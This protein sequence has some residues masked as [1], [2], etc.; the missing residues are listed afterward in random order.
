VEQI[1][2]FKFQYQGLKTIGII[3]ASGI[4]LW[5]IRIIQLNRL[6]NMTSGITNE[7]GLNSSLRFETLLFSQYL[8]IGFLIGAIISGIIFRY[9]KTSNSG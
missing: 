5:F 6:L 9:E 4:L 1:T 7:L 8:F 2:K 3:L